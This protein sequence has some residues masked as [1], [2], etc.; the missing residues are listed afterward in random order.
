MHSDKV[1]EHLHNATATAEAQAQAAKDNVQQFVN[2]HRA[3][4]GQE[5]PEADS[6]G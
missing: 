2:A 5:L 4:T 1:L 3:R 6:N